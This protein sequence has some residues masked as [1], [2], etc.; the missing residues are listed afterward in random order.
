MSS[1]KERFREFI[2][3]HLVPL[4]RTAYRLTRSLAD[5]EDLV[6]DVC[7]RAYEKWEGDGGVD[8]PRAW[9]LRVQYNLH[10]D[11]VRRRPNERLKP[12]D[13]GSDEGVSADPRGGPES[14][15]ET[16]LLIDALTRAWP[17]LTSDQQAL[18][19]LYAEGN[20]LNE[21]TEITGLPLSALKARLHRARLRLGRLLKTEARPHRA[22]A[23]SGESR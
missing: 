6:Q 1:R 2:E 11:A 9:L 5:A 22:A 7:L 8:S 12:L 23:A 4:R 19:A 14:D 21:L 16:A 10:V 18:L 3:P 15:A 17:L 20:T 13:D